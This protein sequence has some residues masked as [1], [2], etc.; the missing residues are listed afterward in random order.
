MDKVG[1]KRF[2]IFGYLLYAPGML[3]FLYADFYLMLLAFFFF[4]LGNILQLNSH[5]VLMGDLTPRNMRGTVNGSTQFF[6]FIVQ[7]ILLIIV[8]YLYAYVAPQLPFLL[9][10]V[11]AVPL[12][13]FVYFKVHEPKVKEQ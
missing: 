10:A 3:L 2:L 6:M 9:L 13:I 4:G 11:T 12:S 5:L 7:A 1:R 8:G